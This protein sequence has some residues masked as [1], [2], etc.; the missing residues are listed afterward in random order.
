MCFL[1]FLLA[2]TAYFAA[3]SA[4]Y[5]T[6]IIGLFLVNSPVGLLPI[7]RSLVNL[8]GMAFFLTWAVD[9]WK[10]VHSRNK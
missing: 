9:F 10:K 3:N 4:R 6:E 8:I 1:A 7:A 2:L 5:L